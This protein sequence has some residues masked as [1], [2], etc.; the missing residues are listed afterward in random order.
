MNKV[1]LTR[2]EAETAAF[3]AIRASKQVR[4][5]LWRVYEHLYRNGP[6][7]IIGVATALGCPRNSVSPRLVELKA[8]GLVDS[9]DFRGGPW[10]MTTNTVPDAVPVRLNMSSP[11]TTVSAIS[12]LSASDLVDKLIA[13]VKTKSNE[14]VM[15]FR[16]ELLSRLGE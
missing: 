15:Y 6:D 14:D 16:R 3:E 7:D 2:R 11:V 1:P 9:S 5:L 12:S 4:G 8:M 13:A 10:S